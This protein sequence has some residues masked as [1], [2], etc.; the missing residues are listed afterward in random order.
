MN[1]GLVNGGEMWA[2]S[3]GSVGG[4]NRV[5]WGC[6]LF[7]SIAYA[8]THLAGSFASFGRAGGANFR[9]ARGKGGECRSRVAIKAR[10]S[11]SGGANAQRGHRSLGK[12]AQDF[13]LQRIALVRAGVRACVAHKSARL[14][15][16]RV[17]TSGRPAERRAVGDEGARNLMLH[18]PNKQHFC[19][20]AGRQRC[21]D[22]CAVLLYGGVEWPIR[23]A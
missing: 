23:S 3:V 7:V 6:I 15:T 11:S 4:G 2:G 1:V 20:P 5:R 18:G 8:L 12:R 22:I 10:G 14:H 21:T 13:P 17:G 19:L 16:K 9:A